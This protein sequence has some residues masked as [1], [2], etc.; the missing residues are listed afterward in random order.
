MVEA[1]ALFPD[2]PCPPPSPTQALLKV[3]FSDL[4]I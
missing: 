4:A 2:T 3:L 1:L